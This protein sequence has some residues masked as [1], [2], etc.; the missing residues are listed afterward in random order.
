MLLILLALVPAAAGHGHGFL[1]DPDNIPGVLEKWYAETL[2]TA[3]EAKLHVVGK[4]PEWLVGDMFNAGPSQQKLGKQ[5][6][7]H[8]FDGFAR[9]N[10][11]T[12]DGKSNSI[13]FTSKMM[14]SK[15][16]NKSME[17]G[18]VIPSTLM[19]ETIPPRRFG[20]VPFANILGPNDNIYVLPWKIGNEYLYVTD[21]ETRI[22]F[23]PKSLK[24]TDEVPY[25][26]YKGNAQPFGHMCGSGSAHIVPDP[27]ANGDGSFIGT[28][29]CSPLVGGGDD[30]MVVYRIA[31]GDIHTRTKIASFKVPIANYMHSYSI[32]KNHVILTGEPYHIN[33][34]KMEHGGTV[35]EA[36][37]YN[38]S[39]GTT[40][41]VVDI[42]TGNV[43]SLKYPGFLF[44][45]TLN[46]FEKDKNT[47]VL[48]IDGVSQKG[49]LQEGVDKVLF[50]KTN[51]DTSLAKKLVRYTLHLDT[52][53]IEEADPCPALNGAT[54]I[55]PRFNELWRGREACFAYAP[56]FMYNSS[57][58]DSG[59]AVK[60]DLC[61]GTVPAVYYK[62]AHFH[63]EL[64]F[65]PRP[66]AT[67]EDD[68]VLL[69]LVFDGE[70]QQSYMNVL[71]GKT[72]KQ[73][74]MAYTPF[75]IPFMLHGNFY[76]RT[77]PQ[78]TFASIV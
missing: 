40:F 50:N 16:Y 10:R 70:S 36:F 4:L 41:Y 23:D 28:M 33:I 19:A 1:P 7:Q 12:F 20:K 5:R 44:I 61:H 22:K 64:L 37:W 78:D 68:G 32:T 17:L 18:R 3:E 59:A 39:L 30:T 14:D 38:I 52:G 21:G 13:V 58:F 76:H 15:F 57:S 62:Y 48:D 73:L 34:S 24:I 72:M 46:A 56:A 43:R 8:I 63:S 69:G 75:R 27:R 77:A 26:K 2:E 42:D 29:G 67:E 71:D 49:Y 55:V 31:A 53:K 74:A 6:F 66:G 51:R 9:T 25:N 45:H 35:S 47:I 11:I 60:M 65:V 54:T